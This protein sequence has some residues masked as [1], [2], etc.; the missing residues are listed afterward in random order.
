MHLLVSEQY[1]DSI[2]H[3]ATIKCVNALKWPV[4]GATKNWT[5]FYT[6]PVHFQILISELSPAVDESVLEISIP[7]IELT[8]LKQKES[9]NIIIRNSFMTSTVVSTHTHTDSVH[10]EY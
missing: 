2:M 10:A 5:G 7:R 8:L 4:S 9:F 6:L 3:G 1:I